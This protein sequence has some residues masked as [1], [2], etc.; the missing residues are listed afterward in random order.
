MLTSFNKFINLIESPNPPQPA[1]AQFPILKLEFLVRLTEMMNSVGQLTWSVANSFVPEMY[2]A[3]LRNN[4]SQC[5]WDEG[6]GRGS[7]C[8]SPGQRA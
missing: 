2:D 1:Q 4:G 5:S 6:G 8:R 7:H 3:D